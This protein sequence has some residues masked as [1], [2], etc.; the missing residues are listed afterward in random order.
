MGLFRRC[1]SAWSQ[2]WSLTMRLSAPTR[3]CA[4]VRRQPEVKARASEA[5]NPKV[6]CEDFFKRASLTGDA[7]ETNQK[8]WPR[9]HRSSKGTH[10]IELVLKGSCVKQMGRYLKGGVLPSFRMSS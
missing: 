7:A 2:H 8:R 3:F 1:W 6:I 5:T 10:R 9:L 4:S